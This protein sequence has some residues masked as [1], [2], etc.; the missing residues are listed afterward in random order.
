MHGSK[1]DVYGDHRFG[2]EAWLFV[3]P[4]LRQD[5]K[6]GRRGEPCIFVEYPS[7]QYGYL[8]WCPSRGPN[9]VVSTSNV[10][11]GTICPK[12]PH[13]Q[14]G[15]LPDTEKEV[16]RTHMP[17]V[18]LV[19]KVQGAPD[20][21]FVGTCED[22][23]VLVSDRLQEPHSLAVTSV[24]DLLY[25]TLNPSLAAAHLSLVDS[26]A[27]V[28]VDLAPELGPVPRT[29]DQTLFFRPFAP[30]WKPAME[31]RKEAHDLMK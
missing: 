30:E 23:F 16:F 2:V 14:A 21:C 5:P 18:F 1:P 28:S 15:L 22:R 11:F 12:A 10:V 25:S 3:Q 13:P 29:P 24:M 8:V 7:N 9:T 27:L 17:V 20:L 4:E 19:E 31:W 26:L 6:L